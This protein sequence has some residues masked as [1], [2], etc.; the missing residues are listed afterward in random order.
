MDWSVVMVIVLS[1]AGVCHCLRLHCILHCCIWLLVHRRPHHEGE[2]GLYPAI[3]VNLA[4]RKFSDIVANYNVAK[5]AGRLFRAMLHKSTSSIV[6]KYYLDG[7]H[8]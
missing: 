4:E 8:R 6:I 5:I 3:T 1:I 2:G 7:H